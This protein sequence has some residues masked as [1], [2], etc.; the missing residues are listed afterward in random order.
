MLNVKTAGT[1]LYAPWFAAYLVPFLHKN[2]AI[3]VLPNYRLAPE[4]NGDD[5]LQDIA[6]FTTWFTSSLPTYLASKEPSLELDFSKVLV[7]GES[8]GAWLALQ[9]VLSLPP[10]TFKACLVHYPVLST[11]PTK[12]D[13]IIGGE[14]LPPKEVL[15]EFLAN[16]KPGSVIS[17]AT[18]PARD[19]V[20]PM[21]RAYGRWGEYFG[22]GKHLMPYTTLEDAKFFVPTHIMHGKDDS[23]VPVGLSHAFVEKARKLFPDT[24]IEIVTP[25]GEHGFDG[26]IYEEDESWLAEFLRKVEE[27]W[28]A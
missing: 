11:I 28:L 7:S 4:N 27:D 15:D 13:D 25:D 2:N 8:A 9:A 26:K 18:P 22:T 17:S 1:A 12:P 10:S 21:L 20:A 6:D 14:S 19:F 5:I 3:A 24:R 23:N 16:L